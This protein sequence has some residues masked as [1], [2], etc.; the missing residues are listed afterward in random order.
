M[1]KPLEALVAFR[2]LV[3]AIAS[4]HHDH[5]LI[6]RDIKTHNILVAADGHLV[7]GDF[8]IVFMA[9]GQR[10]TSTFE[11][12][13]SH[14]WMAPWAYKNEQLAIE[15]INPTLDIFPLGKVLWSMISGRD[16]VSF[17]EWNRDE[18]NLEKMFPNNLMMPLVNRDILSKCIVRE[19]KAC[20]SH[21][22]VLLREID[23]L[24]AQG[25]C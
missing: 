2:P 24:I 23:S 16:G 13:G 17:W 7:L 14:F 20:I 5:G 1:G 11:R 8:G 18:N 12:V 21:A 4:L 22:P 6:H 15:Q 9:D 25:K 3:A 19:E 10:L